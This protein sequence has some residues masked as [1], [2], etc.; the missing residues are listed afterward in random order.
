MRSPVAV[1]AAHG[2]DRNG[3]AGENDQDESYHDVGAGTTLQGLL[4]DFYDRADPTP[5]LLAYIRREPIPMGAVYAF[6]GMIAVARVR[7]FAGRHFDFDD[8]GMPG[9]VIEALGDDAESIED[10]VAWPLD[11]PDKFATALGRAR[12]LGVDQA[13]NPASI[14]G[15]KPLRVWRTPLAWL[16][17]GCQGVVIL[18][19][20][21][22]VLWLG[23]ALGTIAGEDIEHAREIGRLLHPYVNPR[24]V[25]YPLREAA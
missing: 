5:E 12:G 15:G 11:R 16:K 3:Q 9:V 2:A 6:A 22:A 7:F 10:L 14:F 17:A 13:R 21:A 1:G 18:N 23:D 8:D 24:R 19:Q 25:L 20:S 4:A